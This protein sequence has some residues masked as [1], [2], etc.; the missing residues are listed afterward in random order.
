MT[1]GRLGAGS[2]CLMPALYF[3]S[4]FYETLDTV[5]TPLWPLKSDS[6]ASMR[7]FVQHANARK[8]YNWCLCCFTGNYLYIKSSQPSE[9][10]NMA[11]LKSPMLPPAGENGYCFTF[12]HHMFGATVGS[13]RILLQTTD[14]MKKATVEYASCCLNY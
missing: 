11:Q 4:H 14:P 10:G 3:F 13:L 8:A 6:V 5:V 7:F 2:C 9:K 12:W 1:V